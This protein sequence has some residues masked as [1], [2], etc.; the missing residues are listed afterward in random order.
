MSAYLPH[1]LMEVTSAIGRAGSFKHKSIRAERLW[2]LS[3]APEA[4]SPLGVRVSDAQNKRTDAYMAT[5]NRISE[6]TYPVYVVF[7]TRPDT[8]LVR[9]CSVVWS[10]GTIESDF[11]VA[12]WSRQRLL[13]V[14]AG[15]DKLRRTET[16]FDQLVGGW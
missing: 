4:L 16:V 6:N 12:A 8:A 10:N 3:K 15:L 14:R 11:P 5:C 13:Q 9:M 2:V 1:N 7:E